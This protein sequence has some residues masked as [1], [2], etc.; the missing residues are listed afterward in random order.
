MIKLNTKFAALTL[1]FLII[2][3][4]IAIFF[5]DGFIRYTFGDFLATILVY[6]AIK[7]SFNIKPKHIALITIGIAFTLEALQ[8][9]KLLELLKLNHI[10][11]LSIVL[12]SHFSVEDLI[13]YTIGTACIYSIDLKFNTND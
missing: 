6:C 13:A 5:K 9:I 3:I 10:K 4:S 11:W 1:L 8:Y 7:S 12:G 2:E